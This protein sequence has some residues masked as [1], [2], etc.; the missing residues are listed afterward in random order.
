MYFPQTL[1]DFESSRT[2]GKCGTIEVAA[3][4]Y[5]FFGVVCGS[6]DLFGTWSYHH[7][8]HR[9]AGG[10]FFEGTCWM[11]MKYHVS[12]HIDFGLLFHLF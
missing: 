3:M 4:G 12:V 1:E 10:R 6:G 11:Q 8:L 9:D 7:L 5:R 2:G